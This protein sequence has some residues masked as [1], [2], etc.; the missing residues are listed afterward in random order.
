[1]AAMLRGHLSNVLTYFDHRV[2]SATCEGMNNRIQALKHSAF[3]FRNRDH[4]R[5]AIFFHCGGLD[6]RPVLPRKVG[7]TVSFPTVTAPSSPGDP[8]ESRKSPRR[9]PS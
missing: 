3:G 1:V 5:T 6:L 2:T 9:L 8:Q 7:W 4:F